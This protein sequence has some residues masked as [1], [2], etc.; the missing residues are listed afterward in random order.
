MLLANCG[1]LLPASLNPIMLAKE[2]L[3]KE[4][5]GLPSSDLE[6][7]SAPSSAKSAIRVADVAPLLRVIRASI[8]EAARHSAIAAGNVRSS[9]GIAPMVAT[10]PSARRHRIKLA[11]YWR[12]SRVAKLI[13]RRRRSKIYS[14]VTAGI[15]ELVTVPSSVDS[16][17]YLVVKV[18]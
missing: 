16:T 2:L 13:C 1:C 6:I 18:T 7:S 5:L 8:A 17:Q 3:D 14:D 11:R 15:I 9:I 4:S 10:G 12:P